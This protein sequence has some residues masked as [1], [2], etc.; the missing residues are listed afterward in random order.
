MGPHRV[1]VVIGVLGHSNGWQVALW[2][3][4]L[5]HKEGI[6]TEGIFRLSPLASELNDTKLKL[7]AGA[8][9]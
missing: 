1:V 2:D 8:T 7:Q 3:A 9:Q 6:A 4:L 5:R